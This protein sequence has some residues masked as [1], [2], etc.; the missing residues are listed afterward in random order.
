VTSLL[1]DLY[2]IIKLSKKFVVLNSYARV[3]IKW[4]KGHCLLVC[5]ERN[6]YTMWF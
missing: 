4:S 5:A 6:S 1:F 3:S 2:Y